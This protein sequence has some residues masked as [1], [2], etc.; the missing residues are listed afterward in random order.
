MEIVSIEAISITINRNQRENANSSLP[1]L[2]YPTTVV[3]FHPVMGMKG[4]R[5]HL[6]AV[7]EDIS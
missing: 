6:G 4:M 2:S 5:E 1:V 7:T 3:N